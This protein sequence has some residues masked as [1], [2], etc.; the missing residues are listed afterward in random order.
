MTDKK[1]FG[2]FI[3]QKR[4]E[5]N[6]SQK[7][8]AELL[9]I[10]EG[11]VSKW[12]RGASY[13]DITLIADICRVLDISEHEFVTASTDT[14]TRK[15]KHEARLFRR[16]RGAWFW[17]P[18]ISYGVALLTC[19]IC[20]LAVDHTLSWFF[21]VLAALLCAYSFIP[22][23]TLLFEKNKL[24]VF[25]V[26]SYLCICLLLLTCGI[27]VGQ[28]F[29][30][31]TACVGTLMGYVAVF[32]PILLYKTRWRRVCVSLTVG[33]LFLLTLLLLTLVRVYAVFPLF[34]SWLITGYAFL[35]VFFCGAIGLL[36]LNPFIKS[37]IGI[38]FSTTIYFF[39]EFVVNWLFDQND[40]LYQVD[41]HNWER[42]VSG[43][44]HCIMLLSFLF[45]ATAF[46]LVGLYRKKKK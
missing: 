20:N 5:K 27:F 30:V 32:L 34:S 38:S 40:N 44:V 41:F 6:Y 35:P 37:A 3:K 4:M 26:S 29:W 45:L 19:F 43:N 9:F 46:L 7:D 10:T 11:A 31:P 14:D 21:V 22:T 1:S 8:L 13:P 25:T 28:T 42:C 36:C 23:F 17:V 24:L 16:I 18:T 2:S 39:A 15:L 33:A 12:E